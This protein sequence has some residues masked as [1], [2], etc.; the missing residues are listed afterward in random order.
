MDSYN[1]TQKNRLEDSMEKIFLA[2]RYI[3]NISSRYSKLLAKEM[4]L[5]TCLLLCLR[6][7]AKEHGLPIR[8]ISKRIFISPSTVPGIIDRLE[9]RGLV[10]RRRDSPDRWII[11]LEISGEGRK[12]VKSAPVPL[13]SLLAENLRFVRRNFGDCSYDFHTLV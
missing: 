8:Q 7:L 13:Q 9:A 5:A 6:A 12:L 11:S 10:T 1:E 3:A 4:N 2:L